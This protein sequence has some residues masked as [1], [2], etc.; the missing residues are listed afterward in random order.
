MAA[1]VLAPVTAIRTVNEPGSENV[2]LATV[3]DNATL[4]FAIVVQLLPSPLHSST[5][6]PA[7]HAVEP[8]SIPG[9]PPQRIDVELPVPAALDVVIDK[10]GISR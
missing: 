7:V 9:P 5:A 3:A 4:E 1:V 8:I 6:T 2:E 10:A